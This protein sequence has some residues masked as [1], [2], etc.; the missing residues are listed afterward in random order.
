MQD[1]FSLIRGS[2]A[3]EAARHEHPRARLAQLSGVLRRSVW[4]ILSVFI[5]TVLGA[6]SVISLLTEQ[7]DTEAELLVKMG[8]ENLDPPPVSRNVPLSAGLRHEELVSEIEILKSPDLVT[9]VIDEIGPDRFKPVHLPATTFLGE[10]K[11]AIKSAARFVKDQYTETLYALDLRKRLDDRHKAIAGVMDSLVVEAVKDSDVISLKLRMPDPAFAR[12]IEE[13]LITAYLV[14]R[15]Q[16]RQTSGVKE[17]LDQWAAE[18]QTTLKATEAAAEGLKRQE[19]VTSPSEQKSLLLKQI[20]DLSAAEATT[21]GEINA[22]MGEIATSQKIVDATPEYQRSAEQQTPNPARQS[23]E[24]KLISLKL[25]RS[26]ELQKYRADSGIVTSIDQSIQRLTDLLAQE[27]ATQVG[28]VTMQLNPNRIA[29][30]QGLHQNQI[31]LEGLRA[32]DARQK[33]ELEGLNRELSQVESADFR[34]NDLERNRKMAEQEYDSVMKHKFDSDLS[35]ELDRERVS[36]VSVSRYPGSS[37]EPV[38]PRKLLIMAIALAAG[39]IFGVCLALLL[40]Y[41]DDTV[42]DPRQLEIETGLPCLGILDAQSQ[43]A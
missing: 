38:Y 8:R 16:V 2:E 32:M 36:N 1:S 7:Y 40:H 25:Q 26:Q 33:S 37:L 27:K 31:R 29:T 12:E 4:L 30:E 15:V 34:L 42:D 43:S 17:F 22:V 5:L 23:I 41:F 10:V 21:S 39:L 18:R 14:R 24:E 9:Q 28:S 6:Y 11:N 19:G 20:R 13:H 3:A 35:A